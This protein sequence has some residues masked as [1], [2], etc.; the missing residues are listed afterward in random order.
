MPAT[1]K[2]V[3][4]YKVYTPKTGAHSKKPMTLRDAK[5]QQRILNAVEHSDWRPTGKPAKK[6]KKKYAS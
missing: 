4:G 6:K 3:N 2:K 5:A 1:V